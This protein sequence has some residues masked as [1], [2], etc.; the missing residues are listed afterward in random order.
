MLYKNHRIT[1]VAVCI[2]AVCLVSGITPANCRAAALTTFVTDDFSGS[3]VCA[4]CHSRLVDKARNDVSND[5][6]W[7][8]TMMA[9]AA[10]DPL[11]QAKISA[12]VDLV[13]GGLGLEQVIQEKCSRCHMGMARYQQLADGDTKKDIYV[14]DTGFLDP[15]HYLHE[16]AMDGVSCTLCHQITAENL[17]MESSFTGQY[18]IDTT[19]VSP[20]R[21][22]FGPYVSPR[23]DPMQTNA[24]F[25]PTDHAADGMQLADSAHC[26]SCHTL[27]TPALDALGKIIGEFPEQTTYLEWEYSQ[28]N[29]S[30]Q[31]CHLPDAVGSVVISNRPRRLGAREP[32][33]QHHYVG[34]NSYMVN[35]LKDKAAELG[36]TADAN[37][38]DATISRTLAQ[39]QENTATVEASALL[40]DSTLEVTVDVTNLAGHKFPSG[41]PSRRAWLHVTVANA[42]GNILF[43]S[44]AHAND[45]IAGNDAV[46]GPLDFEPHYETITSPDQVQIYEPIMLNNEGAV[47]YTLL[48]AWEY[49]KD[50]RLLP[51]GF[52]KT[53]AHDDISVYGKAFDD[54]NFTGGSDQIV[55]EVDVSGS[56]GGLTVSVELLFQT[57]SY[58][59]IQDLKT[60]RTD[61][62]QRFTNLY[63][64]KDNGPVVI[65][66][67]QVSSE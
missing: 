54:E 57:L 9:N 11:W 15:A 3:G 60:T 33:G 39:L 2:C 44:G 20:D 26:G 51:A 45:R 10:K 48:R 16:A 28:F 13:P 62:V 6:Q 56:S 30:C 27:Y 59:F 61:L 55:Y 41:L 7:R 1:L 22:L 19:T 66:A 23:L 42:G 58:P 63:K 67:V 46:E 37:H 43:E 38:L 25:L 49:A 17:G 32:F 53:N 52:D 5:A 36:V 31:D 24:G 8:S 29:Q 12:E 40:S 34:G 18:V 14:F 65:A 47:T 4:F 50:N 21:V 35:L 64:P